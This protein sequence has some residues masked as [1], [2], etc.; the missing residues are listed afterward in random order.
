LQERLPFLRGLGTSL[1]MLGRRAVYLLS[2]VFRH[3]GICRQS[4]VWPGLW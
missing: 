2:A 3:G 4:S 1:M